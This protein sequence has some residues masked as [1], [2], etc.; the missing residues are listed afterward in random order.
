MRIRDGAA[1]ARFRLGG[2]PDMNRI[3]PCTLA[4]GLLCLTLWGCSDPD[5]NL[6]IEQAVEKAKQH[7]SREEHDQAVKYWTIALEKDPRN[8]GIL[9]NRAAAYTALKEYDLAYQDLT[10][11]IRFGKDRSP[12]PYLNRSSLLLN[13]RIYDEALA[14]V[15]QAI[16]IDPKHGESHWVRGAILMGQKKEAEAKKALQKAR[17]LGFKPI[18]EEATAP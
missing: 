3:A 18:N 7:Q 9:N 14:D 4:A 17:D 10:M 16:K 6:T 11:A 2:T 8:F 1:P 13:A 12:H 5:A 15:E